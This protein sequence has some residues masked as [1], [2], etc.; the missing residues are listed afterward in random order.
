MRYFCVF[1]LVVLNST[2]CSFAQNPPPKPNV[3]LIMADDMGVECLSMNGSLSYQTPVLDN[4]AREGVLFTHCFSQPVCTPSRVKIMTGKYNYRNYVDFGYLDP[5]EKTFGHMMKEA[6]YKTTIAG[7]WQLNGVKTKEKDNQD[8]N[9]PYQMGFEEYCLWWLTEK[10]SRYA[11]PR[12]YQNGKL[13]ETGTDDY[14]PDIVSNYI[15]DFIE[16]NQEQPFFV[17]YPMLLVHSP[18]VPTPDSPA[19]KEPEMRNKQDNK[20][21][22]DMVAYSDKIIGRI[23][24]KLKA[25]DLDENTLIL[26][27]GDNGTSRNIT[28]QTTTGPYQGGKGSMLDNGTHVPMVAYYPRGGQKGKIEEGLVEFSDFVPSLAEAAGIQHIPKSDGKSFFKALTP[29]SYAPR[30]SIFIHYNPNPGKVQK[31]DGRFVRSID[32]KLYHNGRFYDMRNDKWETQTL[33]V[34]NLSDSQKKAYL[35][36]KKELD[37]APAYDFSIPSRSAS[38]K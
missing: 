9:R 10:G 37:R 16:R 13:L 2:S 11:H 21:F 15:L 31:H 28:S 23:V 26:F 32:Y 1:L 14:G 4:L 7:K 35:Q 20:Y 27:V 12:I 18:F 19:W 34:A 17:Y 29:D 36:L 30:S 33:D 38:N 25:L 6:G 8:K 22:G 5:G 3:I 24:S